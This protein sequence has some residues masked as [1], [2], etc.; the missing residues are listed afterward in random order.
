MTLAEMAAILGLRDTS[1][2]R[3]AIQRGALVAELAG[4]T[5]MVKEED[6]ERYRREHQGKRGF[7][8]PNHPLRKGRGD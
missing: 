4:K 6:V 2:L 5:W 1:N 7:A 3:R 8:S